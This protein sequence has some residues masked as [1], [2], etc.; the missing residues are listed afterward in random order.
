[1]KANGRWCEWTLVRKDGS[2][3][4][5]LVSSV[6]LRDDNGHPAGF[7]GVALDIT[8]RKR[9]EAKLRQLTVH[10]EQQVDERTRQLRAVSAELA[11]TEERERR[12]LAQDLHDNLGQLLAVLKIKLTSLQC[13][14]LQPSVDQIID[15]VDQAEQSARML[16]MELSPPILHTLGF[17]PA[18]EWL[19]DEM[20]RIYG[21]KV[22]IDNDSCRKRLIPEIQAILYRAIRELLINV[23]K[24][25]GAVE[26]NLSCLCDRR[27][28]MLAVSDDGCGFD[29]AE[30]GKVHAGQN[31]YGLSSIK[32]RIANIGGVVEIDSS[33]GNGA[34]VSLNVP[35]SIVDNKEICRDPSNSGR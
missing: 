28:L 3:F 24:H 6:A 20:Y 21:L 29:P 8:D 18:L 26:A 25:S 11:M 17:V 9:A 1:M 19:A 27:R 5:A 7:L 10:L 30:L 4:V 33:P 15:L 14:A 12:I 32:E 34:T 16:T 23:A 22:R 13:G 35:C 2:R 31:H